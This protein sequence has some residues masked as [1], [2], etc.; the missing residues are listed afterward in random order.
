MLRNKT[1]K[2]HNFAVIP[3][4]EIPR[5]KFRMKQTRKQAFNASE[6]IPIMCEEVLPGDTW[7][8]HE[9]IAARLATPIA[10]I[11]D[12]MDL[13]TFYFF[14]PNRITWDEQKWEDFITGT[15][16]ALTI[17]TAYAFDGGTDYTIEP[18]SVLDH[19]G[20]LPQTYVG[21]DFRWNVL[22][23]WAYFKIFN[24][25]FRDQ[26]L[27]EE[28]TWPT[29]WTINPTT[30]IE[31]NSFCVW[32]ARR[33]ALIV[34][35]VAEDELGKTKA[36]EILEECNIEATKTV[37]IS[38]N[39]T[40]SGTVEI[41]VFDDEDLEDVRYNTNVSNLEVDFNGEEL[42]GL[43]YDTEDVEWSEY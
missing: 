20:L 5:S 13:E 31:Q 28:W 34:D 15:N 29:T 9:H 23:L 25:W 18:N 16:A 26:N 10:P 3:R 37:S 21:S 1:A 30:D 4:A 40:F 27:Q 19:F 38:G 39:I 14:V 8:H 35:A 17:P 12:D 2:Q 43:E 41:S 22:P 7:Q 36:R 24:E 11:I 42:S 33:I 6:L 32:N